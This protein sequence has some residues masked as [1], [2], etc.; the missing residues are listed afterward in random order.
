MDKKKIVFIIFILSLFLALPSIVKF[1]KGD[2]Q[3]SQLFSHNP[4]ETAVKT[5]VL[6]SYPEWKPLEQ[7]LEKVVPQSSVNVSVSTLYAQQSKFL[8]LDI[9]ITTE[10][11]LSENQIKNITETVCNT[12]GNQSSKYSNI[13]VSVSDLKFNSSNTFSTNINCK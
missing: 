4:I 9:S 10:N 12:L 2:Y 13:K 3:A 6:R 8:D 5:V 11:K 1:I 7:N